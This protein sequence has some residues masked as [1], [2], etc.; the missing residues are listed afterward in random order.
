[1]SYITEPHN[2]LSIFKHRLITLMIRDNINSASILAER[3][4]DTG[5]IWKSK[6][7]NIRKIK[8]SS[9][10]KKIQQHMKE[11]E[12]KTILPDSL[13][14]NYVKAYCKVFNCSPDF[15]LGNSHVISNDY[16]IKTFCAETGFS[17]EAVEVLLKMIPKKGFSSLGIHFDEAQELVND[18][19]VSKSF[20][21][22]MKSI[23]E[24]K[25]EYINLL[26]SDKP[27][28]D[29]EDKI[30][31]DRIN[32]ASYWY[33][34]LDPEYD[35]IKPSQ[36]EMEDC[37]LFSKAVDDSYSIN[38]ENEVIDRANKYNKYNAVKK[39]SDLIDNMYL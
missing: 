7:D 18:I 36:E 15:I 10:E 33:E 21:E 3:M 27:F 20:L 39:I 4:Y 38:C 6:D 26:D 12:R 8:A 32:K 22:V 16:N 37:R 25:K 14:A 24:I 31:K 23:V 19:F 9:I 13:T 5:I 11:G 29:L 30:G 35:G 28:K 2:D 1:M 34:R 17:E